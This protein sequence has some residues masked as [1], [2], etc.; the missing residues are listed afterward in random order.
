MVRFWLDE[1]TWNDLKI[2]VDQF[3]HL[4]THFPDIKLHEYEFGMSFL[5][6]YNRPT[7]WLKHRKG[8]HHYIVFIEPP[9]PVGILQFAKYYLLEELIKTETFPF[10]PG[11][12]YNPEIHGPF[13]DKHGFIYC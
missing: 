12:P 10:D 2:N 5:E 7:V 11:Y 6:N 9:L 8:S 1:K 13:F 4:F 3:W